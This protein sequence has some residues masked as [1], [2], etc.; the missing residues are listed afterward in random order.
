[1][2]STTYP[3]AKSNPIPTVVAAV[4]ATSM[5]S[6]PSMEVPANTFL[7]AAFDALNWLSVMMAPRTWQTAAT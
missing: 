7:Y 4:I 5:F 6:A 1:M 3:T 2:A